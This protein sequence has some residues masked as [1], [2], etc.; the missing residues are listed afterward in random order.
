MSWQ[1]RGLTL[2]AVRGRP[3][4]ALQ[5]VALVVAVYAIYSAV[6]ALTSDAADV[7]VAQ[8]Q[9]I[10]RWQRQWGL[11]WEP[12]IQAWTTESLT[13]THIAN[14]VYF[15]FH[16]PLLIVF[17]VWMFFADRQRFRFLRNVWVITQLIG[18]AVYFL[19]PVAPPRLLPESYG[20]VDTMA[21]LSPINY[22]SAE[23]GPLMNQYAA[24]PSLHF[25]WSVIIAVGLY[26]T[27]PWRPAKA[28]PLLFPLASFWSIVGTGNHYVADALG[29][30]A[31]VTVSFLVAPALDRLLARP[32][33][34]THPLTARR[35]RSRSRS[36]GRR[37]SRPP[38]S[39]SGPPRSPPPAGSRR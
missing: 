37:S 5:Q 39:S 16:L 38:P 1:T 14:T 11:Y 35:S 13:V 20:F 10:V 34:L 9:D 27:L 17:A 2:P 30:A 29:G 28:L 4:D 25:A 7:A 8:A 3:L 6:R 24:F 26:Q 32:S 21:Q 33:P 15:W 23:A 18:V 36:P 22:S 12:D 19:Y 31:V